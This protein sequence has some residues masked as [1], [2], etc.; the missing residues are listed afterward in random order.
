MPA[1]PRGVAAASHKAMILYLQGGRTIRSCADQ[2]GISGASL[3]TALTRHRAAQR[4][5]WPED[6]VS[7]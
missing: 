1:K 3:H 2:Y 5:V 6:E 7:C 4:N